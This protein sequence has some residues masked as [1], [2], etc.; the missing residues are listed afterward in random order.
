MNP[1]QNGSSEKEKSS[2]KMD[3]AG[4]FA[5]MDKVFQSLHNVS[6]HF[7][8]L[9]FAKQSPEFHQMQ[10]RLSEAVHWFSLV[11]TDWKNQLQAQ[12]QEPKKVE[13]ITEN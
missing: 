2:L 11:K 5:L 9:E 13:L 1:G 7:A 6:S 12:T 10:V 3:E 4:Q 8:Q